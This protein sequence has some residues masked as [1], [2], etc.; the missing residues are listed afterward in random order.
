MKSSVH[1]GLQ[2][3]HCCSFFPLETF[4]INNGPLEI[5]ELNI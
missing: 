1:E 2:V 5:V 3:L 4:R